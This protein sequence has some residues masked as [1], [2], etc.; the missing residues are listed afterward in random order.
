MV[1]YLSVP[2]DELVRRLGGRFVCRRCQ[3][4]YTKSQAEVREKS[5]CPRCGGELDQRP[6]DSPERVQKRIEVYHS[7]TV[8]LLDFYR[9]RGLLADIPGLG[10]MEC[11]HR[12]LMEAL[13]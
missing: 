7:E 6:D 2:E 12:R 13:P 4:P 3:A 9:E 10:S 8:P 5:R 11:V 1:L